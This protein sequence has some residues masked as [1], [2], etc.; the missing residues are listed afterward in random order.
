MFFA[1]QW[2]VSLGV[3]LQ[4]RRD[5]SKILKYNCNLQLILLNRVK[6]KSNSGK[7]LSH[8]IPLREG[9]RY[10]TFS[11]S[12]QLFQSSYIYDNIIFLYFIFV[13]FFFL[14][15]PLLRLGFFPTIMHH[16]EVFPGGLCATI[17]FKT[18]IVALVIQETQVRLFLHYVSR[19]RLSQP[20]LTRRSGACRHGRTEPLVPST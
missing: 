5:I 20:K 14:N 13:T 11:V 8:M 9:W 17:F 15:T 19:F 6:R 4:N 2:A 18:M 1:V 7:V 3:F 10:K 12:E 16:F